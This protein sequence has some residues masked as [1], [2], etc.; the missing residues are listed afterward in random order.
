VILKTVSDNDQMRSICVCQFDSIVLL[1][2]SSTFQHSLKVVARVIL[3]SGV[4]EKTHHAFVRFLLFLVVS[5]ARSALGNEGVLSSGEGNVHIVG[6]TAD[7]TL[8][9]DMKQ[10]NMDC[11]RNRSTINGDLISHGM[12]NLRRLCPS[13]EGVSSNPRVLEME[14]SLSFPNRDIITFD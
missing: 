8:P 1:A 7:D 11:R 12:I 10:A 14:T 3:L 6:Q 2:L 5:C 9:C 4:V 13:I